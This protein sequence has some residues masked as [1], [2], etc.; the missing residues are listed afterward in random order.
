MRFFVFLLISILSTSVF[1][2]DTENNIIIGKKH[3]IHSKILNEDRTI[4]INL[5][6]SY[7]QNHKHSRYPVLYFLDGEKFFHSFTGTVQQLSSDATP[8][9]PEMIVVGIKSQQRVRDSSPT[10][11]LLGPS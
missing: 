2:G 11:S 8:H 6:Q 10:H 9:I 4:L 1:A 3:V 7:K 5:P